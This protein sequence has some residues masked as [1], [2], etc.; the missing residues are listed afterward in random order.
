VIIMPAN[1]TNELV[2]LWAAMYGQVGHLYT[3]ARNERLRPWLPYV[4]DNG[5]YAETLAGVPFDADRFLRYVETYVQREQ[6]P[7]WI[8]VPDVPFYGDGT[9]EMY[10][11]W[12]LKLQQYKVPL[13]VVVQ[14]GMTPEI[15]QGLSVKPDVI[16]VGGTYDWKWQTARDWCRVFP[17]VHVGRV[18]S[19]RRLDELEAMGCESCDGSGWFRG[20]GPQVVGLARFL[21]RQAGQDERYAEK[22]ALA[23]RFAHQDQMSM[24]FDDVCDQ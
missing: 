19:P 17:R 16:F 7:R 22:C 12:A 21:A 15:V 1:S 8:A 20:K 2:H 9:V 13:A 11:E 18:N 4:L 14:D 23:T 6:Q 3:P 5:R 10:E 24:R